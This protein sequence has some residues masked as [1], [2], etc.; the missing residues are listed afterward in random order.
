MKKF[1]SRTLNDNKTVIKEIIR[2]LPKIKIFL[3]T[4]NLGSGKTTFIK[5]IAKHLKIKENL[6]SPS[7]I[8][9]QKYKFKFMKKTYFLN[10]IDLYR[11]S[12]Q[13]IFKIDFKK[14]IKKRNSLFF[15]EWGEKLKRYLKN[16]KYCQIIIKKNGRQRIFI[17]K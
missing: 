6:T 4:G 11:I 7:F 9:W 15:I 16:K 12:P 10:H 8:L 3:L 13:D 5:Q 1:I 2:L 14:E 17:L